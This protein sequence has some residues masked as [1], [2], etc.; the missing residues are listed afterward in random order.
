MLA[1]ICLALLLILGVGLL[2]Y[3]SSGRATA[4]ANRP[5]IVIITSDDQDIDSLP[6]MRHMLSYPRGSWV[7]FSNAFSGNSVCTPSR[8]T[9]LTGQYSS[10]NGVW[11]NNWGSE[12]NDYN[13]LPV[14]LHNAGYRTAVIG[15]YLHE[16]M[17]D[18]PGWDEFLMTENTV[19]DDTAL[20][21][22]FI[23]QDDGP[24]FLWLAYRQPHYP[25]IPP[26]RYLDT[27][28]YVAPDRPNFNEA[29]VSDKSAHIRER[30][31][32][33]AT[34]IAE[35]R[36][37]RIRSQRSLL[38]IDDGIKTIVDTLYA[39]GELN[40]TLII[41]HA[42]NGFQWGAHRDLNKLCPYEECSR[43]ALF[44]RYPGTSTNRTET[45]YVSDVDLASTI[46][47]YVD[48]APGL[49]QD[50]DSLIPLI[51][52]SSAPWSDAVLLE[53]P[54]GR[55]GY[56][57]IRVPNWTYIEYHTGEKELYD[58]IADPYQLENKAG[59]P[60]YATIQN[61]LKDQLAALKEGDDPPP[62]TAT[63]TPT[64]TP[65][66]TATPTPTATPPVG[67]GF[68]TI[69]ISSST[70]VTIDGANYANEDVLAYDADTADWSL[71]FDGSDVGLGAVDVDAFQWRENGTLLLS[72]DAPLTLAGAG[73]VDDSD[74]LLFTPTNLGPATAGS[75]AIYIDGSDVGL[76]TA[77][78]DIDAIGLPGN[79]DL[80]LS[81]GGNAS[82]NGLTARDEDLLRLSPS[83]TGET[84]LGSWTLYFD[85][86]DVG[87]SRPIE[88]V[89]GVYVDQAT[90]RLY[91]STLGNFDVPGLS[92]RRGD[93]FA[94]DPTALGDTTQCT[95]DPAPVWRGSE[96][97]GS[98]IAIDGLDVAV[99]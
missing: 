3:T 85:G 63:P 24:F 33:S 91:L 7:N 64:A 44:I 18:P 75:F 57:A 99:D 66:A 81:V 67:A 88:D 53:R 1:S 26:D 49:P 98:Y 4:Q 29:D 16:H 84:T 19:D 20:G 5:N 56:Y 2:L 36:A 40:N 55:V 21:V 28:V 54:P 41:F 47:D 42:D 74:V 70:D 69:Y 12:F 58:M 96:A 31:L 9:L 82:V 6:V 61:Q 51:T 50:G 25:A 35:M 71:L 32:L 95:F 80:L 92:G 86:S 72:L 62:G 45:H 68:Q 46:L 94:C 93:V 76:S 52:N 78:E 60:A 22:D 59:R 79:G 73:V 27:D 39:A 15:K 87:L 17:E 65:T 8:A 23:N 34:K 37:E 97:A 83:Q 90:G 38:A 13:A 30:P 77:A 89:T 43:V 48:V 10:T 11:G 14:W